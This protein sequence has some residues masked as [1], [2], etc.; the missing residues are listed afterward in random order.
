MAA[1]EEAVDEMPPSRPLPPPSRGVGRDVDAAGSQNKLGR[2]KTT[3]S[4][5]A[6][7]HDVISAVRVLFRHFSSFDSGP[8]YHTVL[9]I[10]PPSLRVCDAAF[11][12]KRFY[13]QPHDRTSCVGSTRAAPPA[14]GTKSRSSR[15]WKLQE[16]EA[17]QVSICL[18]DRTMIGVQA[19]GHRIGELVN[20]S[21]VCTAI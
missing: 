5:L 16:Q 20:V 19:P 14:R 3:L 9:F 13:G 18:H 7:M 1:Q 2:D 8:I 4:G 15:N 11:C 17:V 12:K 6:Q 21:L 10:F